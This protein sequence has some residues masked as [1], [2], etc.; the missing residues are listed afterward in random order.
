MKKSI[1]NTIATIA[2]IASVSCKG[3]SGVFSDDKPLAFVPGSTVNLPV[4]GGGFQAATVIDMNGDGVADG[5]DL[6]GNGV[7]EILY[8]SL[9]ADR[10][11]GLD[12]NGDGIIDF[13][14]VINFD[15]TSILQ[16]ARSGGSKVHVTKDAQGPSGFDT[17]DDGN[18]NNTILT[19]IRNDSTPPTIGA[20]P[21]GGTFTGPQSITLTCSDSVACN[22]IAFTTDGSDPNFAGQTSIIVPGN[23]ASRAITSTTTVRY[24][25]RDAKGNVSGIGQQVYTINAGASTY[26]IGGTISGLS[27]TVVL[28]NNAGNNLSVSAIGSFAFST[29]L[30]TG[31]N[32]AVTVLTQPTGQ[33]CTVTSGSGTVASANVTNVSVSCT[34]NTYTIGG[35]ISGLS[36]T[37][38]LQNNAGNDLSLTTNGSFTFSTSIAHNATYSVTVL[39]Q[40]AGQTCTVSS[41]SG[42]VNAANVTGVGVSCA[43]VTCVLNTSTLDNC[44][45]Q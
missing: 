43:S 14:L 37:V 35:T 10:A 13:Y 29:T 45:L 18:P 39:T 4:A 20:S 36:G 5:L 31:T 30:T 26:S 2:L 9:G 6:D 8:I 7:P 40:P 3:F 12:L 17:D 27:G 16:T 38:V 19:S 24:I 41:G 34:N 33:T 44:K 42:T 21:I 25:T 32:Y 23:K 1:L 28:Q 22:A 15:G 11:I